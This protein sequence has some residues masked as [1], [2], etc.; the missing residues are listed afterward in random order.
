MANSWQAPYDTGWL[1]NE[2]GGASTAD[3]TN[4]HL[5]DDPTDPADTVTHGLNAPLS[6]LLVRLLVSS[7]GT[8]NNSIELRGGGGNTG[9]AFNVYQIDSNNI[10]IQ[11]GSLG[12]SYARDSDGALTALNTQNWYYKVRVYYLG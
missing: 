4:V 5:G 10:K 1:L 3:W 9:Y 8:D 6:K 2:L 12:L 7:D 11:T